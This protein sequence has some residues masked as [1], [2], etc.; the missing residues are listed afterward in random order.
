V[1]G[2]IDMA[3]APRLEEAMTAS[4]QGHRCAFLLDLSECP[5]VDSGGL[6]VLFQTVRKLDESAWLGVVGADANLRR[7]FQIVGLTSVPK[8]L[9]FDD[10]AAAG[11][12]S[13]SV[14]DGGSGRE[15]K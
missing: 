10:L 12:Y 1:A 11:A 9:M 8:F 14:Q 4:S 6:S 7:I 5:F 15:K 2:E 13:R 3:T